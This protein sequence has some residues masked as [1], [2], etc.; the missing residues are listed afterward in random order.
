VIPS[1]ATIEKNLRGNSSASRSGMTSGTPRTSGGK[2]AE[3]D[4]SKCTGDTHRH[5]SSAVSPTA[6]AHA[7]AAVINAPGGICT[8]L[9]VPVVPDV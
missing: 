3:K 8:P 4:P 5:V 7:S 2:I 9:G 6:S 1:A